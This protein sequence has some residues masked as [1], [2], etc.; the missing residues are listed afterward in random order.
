MKSFFPDLERENKSQTE[1]ELNGF[2]H[3]THHKQYWKIK[4]YERKR[5]GG[6]EER[7]KRNRAFTSVADRSQRERRAE[8]C[9]PSYVLRFTSQIIV[10]TPMGTVKSKMLILSDTFT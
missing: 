7:E 5:G 2:K 6:E 4:A 10:C 8:Q 1:K 9:T 3:R